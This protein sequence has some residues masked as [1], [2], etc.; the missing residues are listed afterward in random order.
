MHINI[1]MEF[2]WI[3]HKILVLFESKEYYFKWTYVMVTPLN[4]YILKK[5]TYFL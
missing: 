5:Y 2:E 3:Y 1:K 4:G